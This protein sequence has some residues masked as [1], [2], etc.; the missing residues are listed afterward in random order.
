MGS[1]GVAGLARLA[2]EAFARRDPEAL[3]E[4]ADP[5]VEVHL[6]TGQVAGHDGPYR[7]HDG[8]RAYLVDVE[9][10][11]DEIS[12]QPRQFVELSEGRLLVLGRVRTRRGTTH[13]D[14]P[15][16]W[17]WETAAGKV[18]SVR[19]LVDAEAVASLLASR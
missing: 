8:I 16:A 15:S 11:W 18:T 1:N 13:M 7:G 10:A 9:A 17:L 4:I 3:V 2:Y 19:L 12:L 6:V 14:V 5:E